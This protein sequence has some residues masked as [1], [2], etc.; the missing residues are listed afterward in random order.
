MSQHEFNPTPWVV[1]G[2]L[3]VV[4]SIGGGLYGCPQY[5]V[6]SAEQDGKAALAR[7]NQSREITVREATA[8]RDAAK[9]LAEAE[10]ER[11]KGV[12]QANKI[13]GDSGYSYTI[14]PKGEAEALVKAKNDERERDIVIFRHEVYGEPL[15]QG[16]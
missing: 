14:L 1:L 7:A 10:I 5:F 16:V 2:G 9:M 6:Y 4:L 15:P 12:A 13:I 8:R 11:A 3:L